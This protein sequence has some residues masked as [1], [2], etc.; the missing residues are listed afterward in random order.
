MFPRGQVFIRSEELPLL[1]PLGQVT[2]LLFKGF[3]VMRIYKWQQGMFRMF[4]NK[5]TELLK[6]AGCMSVR[7]ISSA[8]KNHRCYPLGGLIAWK[9]KGTSQQGGRVMWSE[10]SLIYLPLILLAE[11]LTL[12]I[13]FRTH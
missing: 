13:F 9:G 1:L 12:I 11:P 10:D 2:H 3:L 8:T 6:R 7:L 4:Q 5:R